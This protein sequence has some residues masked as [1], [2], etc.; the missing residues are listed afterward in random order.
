MPAALD[1]H[2]R[3]AIAQAIRDGGTRNAIARQHDVSPATVTLIAQQDGITDAFNR[4]GTKRA[5]EARRIDQAAAS[6]ALAGRWSTFSGKVL[7]SLERV[8]DD[9][10]DEVGLLD[11]ARIAG[12]AV[13]KS[14]VLQRTG[15]PGADASQTLVAELLEGLRARVGVENP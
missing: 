7:A 1:P 8:T 14:L 4:E 15:D 6:L 10:W 11:R 13:D 3:A 9:E 2:K 5:T 12:I